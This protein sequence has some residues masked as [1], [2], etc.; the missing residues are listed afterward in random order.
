MAAESILTDKKPGFPKLSV[1][2][3][4]HT[5]EI[6]YVGQYAALLA[7]SP[8]IGEAWGDYAGTV[9][10]VSIDP[11]EGATTA[12][13]SVTVSYEF[14][15]GDFSTDPGVE[16]ETTYEIE[17]AAV[18]RS[19]YEHP[20]FAIGLLGTY[21]LTSEDWVAI[22]KWQNE[23]DL[24]QKAVFKY[25]EK[26]ADTT[27]KTLSTNAKMFA[28]G[29]QLGVEEW[30]DF[31][32][33]VRVTTTYL[34]GL[35]PTGSAGQKDNPPSAANGPSGYEWRKSADRAIKAGGQ[36]KWERSQEWLGAK[37]VLVDKDDIFWT[38]P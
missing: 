23:D 28:R 26:D 31:A 35:P 7:A 32:P 15:A 38:A 6:E 3:K 10:R 9:T 1:G 5:T 8:N 17:W 18:S 4:E 30:D 13:L 16:Q 36:N 11:H 33:V 19:M 24:T 21:A 34:N 20:E 37:K 29:I 27:Y 14:E 22:E 12:E 2:Q 25:K